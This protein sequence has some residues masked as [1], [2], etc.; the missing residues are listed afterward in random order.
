M[1]VICVLK[2]FAKLYL[3]TSACNSFRR[4]KV[5]FVQCIQIVNKLS[6]LK[7]SFIGSSADVS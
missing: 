3:P 4:L 7:L 6:S 5:F 1:F 2:V